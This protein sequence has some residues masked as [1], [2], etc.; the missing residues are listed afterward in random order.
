VVAYLRG[1]GGAANPAGGV[2]R[3]ALALGISQSGRYLRDFRVE[4][5]FVLRV[6][7]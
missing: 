1:E 2:I 7:A 4:V 6:G 3:H 5:V